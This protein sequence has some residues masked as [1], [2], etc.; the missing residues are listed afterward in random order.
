MSNHKLSMTIDG[1]I[2]TMKRSFDAPR[3]L[4]WKANTDPALLA[5]WWGQRESTT[6]IDKL[7][8]RPGGEWRFVQK[9]P[10]G[11]EYGFRGEYQEDVPPVRFTTTFE[12]ERMPG[13][14][15]VETFSFTE[16]NGITTLTTVATYDSQEDLDAMVGS[17]MEV[18]AAESYDR[19]EEFLA[20]Q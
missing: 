17:G 15:L 1:L 10:D 19:L 16:T 5:Q 4:V 12:F 14:I 18:G 6:I 8:L 20:K 3:D 7:D 9:S 13:H 11:A 2:I